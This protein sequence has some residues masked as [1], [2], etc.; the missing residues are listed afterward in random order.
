MRVVRVSTLKKE[1]TAVELVC[2]RMS[3]RRS[4]IA[5]RIFRAVFSTQPPFRWRKRKSISVFYPVGIGEAE[6]GKKGVRMEITVTP[7]VVNA[8][9]AAVSGSNSAILSQSLAITGIGMLILFVSL[10][11]LWAVM[12][13]LVRF[14]KDGPKSVD[15][16]PMDGSDDAGD[17]AVKAKV[18]AAAAGYVLS[19]KG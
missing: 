2:L 17:I 11:V 14:V 19:K 13:L 5:P 16:E 4:R 12:E 10:L 6:F 7:E 8:V 3:V 9:D 18:A 15:D 1:K